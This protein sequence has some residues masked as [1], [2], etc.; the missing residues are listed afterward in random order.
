MLENKQ[1]EQSD[2]RP[3]QWLTTSLTGP[4]RTKF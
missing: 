1:K 2:S 4:T 3:R